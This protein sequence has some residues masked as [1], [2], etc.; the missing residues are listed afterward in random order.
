MAIA[1]QAKPTVLAI[2]LTGFGRR[3]TTLDVYTAT[4]LGEAIATIRLICFDLL[5]VGLENPKLDVWSL[6]ER[7]L[8]AWP[9]QRWILTSS[10]VTAADEVQARS[11]GA[12]MVLSQLPDETWLADFVASLRLRDLSRGAQKLISSAT[13]TA[14]REG[15]A[16]VVLIS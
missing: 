8:A 16:N 14:S 11:L 4:T 7:V 3:S 15:A 6:I 10:R 2:G 12:L 1:Q 5:L 9:Q 13:S